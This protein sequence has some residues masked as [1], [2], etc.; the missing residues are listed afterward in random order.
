MYEPHTKINKQKGKRKTLSLTLSL[1]SVLLGLLYQPNLEQPIL[2]FSHLKENFIRPPFCFPLHSVFPLRFNAFLPPL[3]S[4]SLIIIILFSFL[5]PFNKF[6][7][8]LCS[9]PFS[10]SL[11]WTLSNQVSISLCNG[12]VFQSSKSFLFFYLS[13]AS[14]CLFPF[15]FSYGGFS[16]CLL[17]CTV[18][19][20]SEFDSCLG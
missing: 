11:C 15:F 1:F 5:F 18:C 7:P 3:I 17:I 4:H 13:M 2:L 6:L 10:H 12:F 19:V 16:L 9:N 8:S 14:C 20:F